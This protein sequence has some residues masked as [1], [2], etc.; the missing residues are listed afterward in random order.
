MKDNKIPLSKEDPNSGHV[1]P[2]FSYEEAGPMPHNWFHKRPKTDHLNFVN[3]PHIV[4]HFPTD[5]ERAAMKFKDGK[6][7]EPLLVTG[8]FIVE[9]SDCKDHHNYSDR[10]EIIFG[11]RALKICPKCEGKTYTI[12]E[13]ESQ[14]ILILEPVTKQLI[15]EPPPIKTP[16]Q[17]KD[18]IQNMG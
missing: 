8:D 15:N 13:K 5:Q 10:G 4:T 1:E 9:C 6:I 12:I 11:G 7:P 18:P 14:K 16:D 17:N 3:K 2:G